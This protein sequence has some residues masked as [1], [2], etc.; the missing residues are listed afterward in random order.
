[1]ASGDTFSIMPSNK[2]VKWRIL[3]PLIQASIAIALLSVG[4]EPKLASPAL[5]GEGQGVW[6][7]PSIGYVPPAWQI[8]YAVN[9]PALLVTRILVPTGVAQAISKSV[10]CVTI[11]LLWYLTIRL[12]ETL[13]V[14]RKS[15]L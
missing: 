5:V 6:N 15:I 7:P 10:F 12:V 4:A 1:M 9:F 3:L 8:V 11:L 14:E 13:H 2:K